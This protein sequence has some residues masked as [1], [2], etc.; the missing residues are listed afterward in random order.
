[1]AVYLAE[2]EKRLR[3]PRPD[4]YL[5]LHGL[6]LSFG[7]FEWPFHQST[8]GADTFLVHGEV[9]LEDGNE[10]ILARRRLQRR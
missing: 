4:C 2:S 3:N 1:M 5:T 8:S 6:P 7:K 9:R 10:S